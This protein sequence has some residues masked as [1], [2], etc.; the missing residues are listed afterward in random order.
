[1]TSSV[2]ES[3]VN[4]RKDGMFPAKFEICWLLGGDYNWVVAP[5]WMGKI[6]NSGEIYIVSVAC[7]WDKN[8]AG[9]KLRITSDLRTRL[10]GSQVFYYNYF[11]NNNK[12]MV[13]WIFVTQFMQSKTFFSSKITFESTFSDFIVALDSRRFLGNLELCGA[14]FRHDFR[15]L[16]HILVTQILDFPM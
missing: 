4:L 5:P 13:F 15:P 16:K 3:F 8:M 6:K 1:M 11:T 2:R 14:T 12:N 10:C 9:A 7:T